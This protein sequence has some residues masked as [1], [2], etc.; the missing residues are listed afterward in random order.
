MF[1]N[2]P[3]LILVAIPGCPLIQLVLGAAAEFQQLSP[4]LLEKVQDTGNGSVLLYLGLSKGQTAHMD[5]K[6]AGPGLM[7]G[8]A[9]IHGSLA[10]LLPGHL[11]ELV[12]QGHR[13][14]DDLK[15]FFQGA[16]MLA[17]DPFLFL[18][19][20]PQELFGVGA[21]LPGAIDFQFHAKEPGAVSIENRLRLVAVVLNSPVAGG[22]G[23]AGMTERLFLVRVIPVI[24][25]FVVAKQLPAADAVG[26]IAAIATL[27]ERRVTV[28]GIVIGPDPFPADMTG[29]GLLCKTVGAKEL[30]VELFLLGD[31]IF[32]SA[33]RADIG[34]LFHHSFLLHHLVDDRT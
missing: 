31:G 28:P 22:P 14:R 27:A 13:V 7:A 18:I 29:H 17:V 6:A 8:V 11:P 12:G 3:G 5:V 32:A 24:V 4:V 26:V 16:V 15:S 25:G 33:D 21:I 9:Q 34:F 30:P 20:D 23:I 10:N 19:G 2:L 1:Q